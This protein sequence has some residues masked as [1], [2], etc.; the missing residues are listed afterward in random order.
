MSLAGI[1]I[2]FFFWADQLALSHWGLREV[3]SKAGPH[4][5]TRERCYRDQAGD[6]RAQRGC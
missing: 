4:W 3:V 1:Q 5:R 6:I 2:D